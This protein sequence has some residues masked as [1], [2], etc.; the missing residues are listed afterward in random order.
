MFRK[1]LIAED[2]EVINLSV[3]RT[4]KELEIP[5]VDQVFYCD[6]ALEKVKKSLREDDPYDLIITDLYYDEDHHPQNL[7]N[8]KEM[9]AAIKEIQPDVKVI[10][11]SAEHKSG[12]IDSL[13]TNLKIDGFVRKGRNDAK[14]L[15]K[16]ITMVAEGQKYLSLDMKHDLKE[17]NSY[18]FTSYDITLVSLLSQGVFLKNIPT[19]L[20]NNNIKPHSLSSVEKKLTGLR[21]G[22]KINNNEQLVAFCKDLG[23]I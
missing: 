22:L 1:I 21:E 23:L 9:I 6:D 4:V 20:Q 11:F 13:F 8:G 7:K 17:L 10:F 16:A 12:V 2:H 5:T 18:E 14:E 3:Q 15:K 19:Y